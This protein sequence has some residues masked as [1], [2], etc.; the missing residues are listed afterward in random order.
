MSENSR[1]RQ[2]RKRNKELWDRPRQQNPLEARGTP[3]SGPII[4]ATRHKCPEHV[5]C[6]ELR[7]EI[8]NIEARFLQDPDQLAGVLVRD[9][10]P[11]IQVTGGARVTVVAHGVS[12]DEEILNAGGVEQWKW[13]VRL[14]NISLRSAAGCHAFAGPIKGLRLAI[15]TAKACNPHRLSP[16]FV[17]RPWRREPAADAAFSSNQFLGRSG[18]IGPGRPWACGDSWPRAVVS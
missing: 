16:F 3:A 2:L 5:S 10:H 14:T 1:I 11:K 15:D 7:L 17:W 9:G 6:R 18:W 8:R 12:A 13:C 4:S